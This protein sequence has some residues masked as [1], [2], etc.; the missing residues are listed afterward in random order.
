MDIEITQAVVT[1]NRPCNADDRVRLCTKL[2]PPYSWPPEIAHSP[3]NFYFEVERGKGV[4]Y[5]RVNFPDVPIKQFDAVSY[6]QV[7]IRPE[8]EPKPEPTIIVDEGYLSDDGEKNDTE[9]S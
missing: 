9:V 3:L 5:I 8:P 4:E 2:P 7:D 1:V 6:Q